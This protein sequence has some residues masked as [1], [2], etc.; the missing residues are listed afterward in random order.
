M[1]RIIIIMVGEPYRLKFLLII[2][3]SSTFNIEHNAVSYYKYHMPMVYL[4]W[5]QSLFSNEP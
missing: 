4:Q 1:C 3:P 5:L 2:R